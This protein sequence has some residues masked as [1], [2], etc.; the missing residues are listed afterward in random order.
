MHTH[1]HIQYIQNKLTPILTPILLT[2]ILLTSTR[3]GARADTRPSAGFAP[4]LMKQPQDHLPDRGFHLRPIPRDLDLP[5]GVPS[6]P[7][8]FRSVEGDFS[9]REP[10]DCEFP[11]VG[12]GGRMVGGERG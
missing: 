5:I 9:C 7:H 8:S 2:P 1:I 6:I 12:A 11:S 10:F 3:I 4:L